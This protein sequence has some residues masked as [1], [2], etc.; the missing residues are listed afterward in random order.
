MVSAVFFALFFAALVYRPKVCRSSRRI[1]PFHVF[2]VLRTAGDVSMRGG[3]HVVLPSPAAVG[4]PRP[5]R[6]RLVRPGGKNPVKNVVP[7]DTVPGIGTGTGIGIGTRYI[8]DWSAK[9]QMFQFFSGT[10]NVCITPTI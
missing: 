8:P 4:R 1:R 3:Q 2:F 10:T 5:S 7:T 9:K 6:G